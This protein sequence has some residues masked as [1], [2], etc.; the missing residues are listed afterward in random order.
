[1]FALDI[2]YGAYKDIIETDKAQQKTQ[3]ASSAEN[4]S[5]EVK[6]VQISL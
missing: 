2:I 5:E 1:M 6:R 4:K 3:P